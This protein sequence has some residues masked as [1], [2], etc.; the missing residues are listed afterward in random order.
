MTTHP[1]PRAQVVGTDYQDIKRRLGVVEQLLASGAGAYGA[2]PCLSTGHPVNPKVG[3]QI[4][5]TD[6]GLTAYYNG[7]AWVYAP[8][9]I[10]S[11]VLGANAT[12]VPLPSTGTIP[13][14]FRNLRLIVSAKST[15]TTAGSLDPAT[16][17]FNGVATGYNW[18]SI[19]LA[20]GGAAVTV[21]GGSSATAAQCMQVWN[22]L[23]TSQGRGIS[24]IRIPNYSDST[25]F[26]SFT[27]QSEASDGGTAGGMQV[28]AGS[29]NNSASPITGI[30]IAMGVGQFV[31]GSGF[32]L[33]GE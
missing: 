15:G 18:S 32:W 1:T 3:A 30:T 6:T 29:L 4:L 33:Y 31:A 11:V 28:Y 7:T 26:K 8:Q 23:H 5:E 27:A 19:Q 12:S 17:Q 13:Q 20:Q 16:I 10:T 21:P 9:L 25:A 24:E 14:V 2:L 22:N